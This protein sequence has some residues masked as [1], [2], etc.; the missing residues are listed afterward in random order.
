MRPLRPRG[1]LAVAVAVLLIAGLAAAVTRSGADD[2]P[3]EWD[4]RVADL[5]AFVE[6]ERGLTFEHPVRVEFLSDAAFREEVT[7]ADELT[8]EEREELETIEA[9]LRAM[10]LV[11]GD[12]DLGSLVDELIGDGVVGLYDFE[13]E[14]IVVRG[15]QMDDQRR[16]TVVH[17]LTHAL[18]DQH[19]DVGDRE[20]ETSGADAA[21]TAVVEADAEAVE[22]EW[23]ET[24][25]QEARRALEAAD[26]ATSEAADFEGVPDVFVELLGFPYIFGPDLLEAVVAER[27]ATGRNELLRDPPTTEEHVVLPRTYLQR[28]RARDVPTPSLSDDEEA[29]DDTEGDFGMMSLVVVLAERIDFGRAWR[30]VQGWSGDASIAFRRGKDV[31]VRTDVVFD[32]PEQADR[33]GAAFGQW[34]TDVK[35]THRVRGNDVRFESCDPGPGAVGGRRDGH[36]SGIEGLALRRE[37][38]KGFDDTFAPSVEVAECVADAILERLGADRFAELDRILNENPDDARREEIRAAAVQIIPT[39][40]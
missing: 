16:S 4:P 5:A 26:E 29:I 8:E 23:R 12:V 2:H 13:E 15:E 7:G 22:S 18:Q 11:S 6:R 1:L 32:L 40:Q 17:E 37:L 27:G 21:L 25:S 10:A 30:A 14:R 38:V 19:F 33:F 20:P 24:L 36:V 39:C 35:G 28:D 34:A 9:V 31:C 3:D